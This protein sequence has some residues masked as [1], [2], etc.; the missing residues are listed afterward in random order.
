M[1]LREM[2]HTEAA[3]LPRPHGRALPVTPWRQEL[4]T[5][6][7]RMVALIEQHEDPEKRF[8]TAREALED[9]VEAIKGNLRD[10]YGRVFDRL[11][12]G[13]AA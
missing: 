11:I 9:V 13:D 1:G 2:V 4:A 7:E 3:F 10:R 12:D 8:W 5:L 6:G